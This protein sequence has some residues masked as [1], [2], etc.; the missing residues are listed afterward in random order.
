M[1]AGGAVAAVA[2]VALFAVFAGLNDAGPLV[3][4]GLRARGPGPLAAPA[5]LVAAVVLVPLAVGTAV[6]A[7]LT[8]RLAVCA[9]LA[10]AAD[11]PADGVVKRFQ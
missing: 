7:T 5:V 11:A 8:G 4:V 9:L 10:A 6:A 3:G 1:T 2:G